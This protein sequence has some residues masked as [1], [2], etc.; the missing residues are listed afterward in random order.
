MVLAESSRGELCPAAS[1][2]TH[3]DFLA[4]ALSHRPAQR[5]YRI[6]LPS[7]QRFISSDLGS[8]EDADGLPERRGF[9]LTRYDERLFVSAIP[10]INTPAGKLCNR[11][12][13]VA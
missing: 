9:D 4:G 2:V 12:H 10:R 13:E 5:V 8:F 3:H 6:T 7:I 11:V 1:V